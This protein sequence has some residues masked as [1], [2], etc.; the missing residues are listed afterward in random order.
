M[1]SVDD[2]SP[3]AQPRSVDVV[4]LDQALEALTALDA[5]QSSVVELRFFGALDIE[6]AAEALG[7]SP[8]ICALPAWR[9]RSSLPRGRGGAMRSP[10]NLSRSRP[11]DRVTSQLR[12]SAR[13]PPCSATIR[14]REFPTNCITM[15]PRLFTSCPTACGGIGV[16]AFRQHAA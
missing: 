10:V 3:A 12:H 6:E 2:V 11:I 9:L 1:V 14:S 15:H 16:L 8:A 13:D 4:A 7:I 5:R